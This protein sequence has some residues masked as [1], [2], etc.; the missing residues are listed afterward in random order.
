MKNELLIRE[1]I[2]HFGTAP[3]LLKGRTLMTTFWPQ[4]RERRKV[5]G[6]LM[7]SLSLIL[8]IYD[9]GALD[10]KTRSRN[11]QRSQEIIEI[12]KGQRDE[13][14]ANCANN[15]RYT[16]LVEIMW[17]H[18]ASIITTRGTFFYAFIF[19]SSNISLITQLTHSLYPR[20]T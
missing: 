4:A 2:W 9:R 18:T 17:N 13:K 7:T 16:F 12:G 5:E 8:A 1:G 19:L 10:R 6:L 3:P 11:G 14:I 15:T 20:P